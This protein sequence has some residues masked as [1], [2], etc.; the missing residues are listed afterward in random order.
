MNRIKIS[1]LKRDTTTESLSILV[2]RGISTVHVW[3]N[4]ELENQSLI[5]LNEYCNQILTW[6]SAQCEISSMYRNKIL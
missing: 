2:E 3:Y 5:D 1:S 4:N 6:C